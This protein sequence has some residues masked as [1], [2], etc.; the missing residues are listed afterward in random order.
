MLLIAVYNPPDV[1]CC[2]VLDD[3]LS[4]YSIKYE[5][6]LLLGDFNTNLLDRN[7]TRTRAFK[8]I[9]STFS[10]S[11]AGHEL[12]HFHRNGCSQLDLI[13]SNDN[14]KILRFSQVDIPVLSHHDLI[15]ASLDFDTVVTEDKVIYRDY[16][17]IDYAGLIDA[18]HNFNWH[19]FYNLSDSN[20]LLDSFN[21]IIMKL[22][23]SFVPIRSRS[24]RH[25]VNPWFNNGIARAMVDRDLAFKRFKQ[26]KTADDH[27]SY[28]RLRNTVTQLIRRAKEDYFEANLDPRLTPKELWK[29]IKTFG[30]TQSSPIVTSNFTANEINNH[31][32]KNFISYDMPH[33]SS[34]N[35]GAFHFEQIESSDV[36]NALY[37]TKSSLK[38][39]VPWLLTPYG[40]FS[41]VL[42][43]RAIILEHGKTLK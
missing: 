26:S 7:S 12:T 29:K 5:N 19:D 14:S 3:L 34:E 36:I 9:L 31:F 40:T 33:Q 41:I 2:N 35:L 27:D 18:Y 30:I 42:S 17:S 43:L 37:E 24:L 23:E 20:A 4:D 6:I 13:L 21:T 39:F 1:D 16:N 10:M 38:L 32:S 25:N 15:F 11:S 8:D 28:K 22:H